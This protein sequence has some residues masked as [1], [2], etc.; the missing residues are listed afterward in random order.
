[1]TKS[2]GTGTCNLSVNIP[3]DERQILGRAAFQAGA[4]SVGDFVKAIMLRGLTVTDAEA[5]ARVRGVRRMY[6][7]LIC[8]TAFI[9]GLVANE[10]QDARRTGR[11]CRE[12]RIE[13]VRE[14][15]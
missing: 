7:G 13:E 14:C 15:V 4:K 9:I 10:H 8:L 1:M 6:Y 2:I 3:L 11:R 5:A 12:E